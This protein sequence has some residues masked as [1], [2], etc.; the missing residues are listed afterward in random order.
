ML[1]VCF[2]SDDAHLAS[3]LLHTTFKIIREL[4]GKISCCELKGRV[5][6]DRKTKQNKIF[7]YHVTQEK[8]DTFASWMTATT[9]M[10]MMENF[11]KS[12]IPN[13]LSS[14]PPLQRFNIKVTFFYY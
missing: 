1:L 5:G 14:S 9:T 12:F 3:S 7:F 11:D 4:N 8:H 10:M 6:Y 13:L 2:V